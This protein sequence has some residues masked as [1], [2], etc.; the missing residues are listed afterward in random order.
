V[1]SENNLLN[2]DF[3]IYIK[4]ITLNHPG[5]LPLPKQTERQKYSYFNKEIIEMCHPP[6]GYAHLSAPVDNRLEQLLAQSVTQSTTEFC[7]RVS[8]SEESHSKYEPFSQKIYDEIKNKVDGHVR[9][10]FTIRGTGVGGGLSQIVRSINAALFWDVSCLKEEFFFPIAHDV[11]VHQEIIHKNTPSPVWSHSLVKLCRRETINDALW[12]SLEPVVA[13]TKREEPQTAEK[14]NIIRSYEEFAFVDP[15]GRGDYCEFGMFSSAAKAALQARLQAIKNAGIS[16]SVYRDALLRREEQQY[17]LQEAKKMVSG[18][19]FSAF[20]MESYL[21]AELFDGLHRD[22]KGSVSDN[23]F[24]YVVCDA[25]LTLI[26]TFV[27]E[28]V[29]RK[30]YK[31]LSELHER[32]SAS[33]NNW[34][35]WCQS[36]MDESTDGIPNKSSADSFS[37]VL[38]VRYELC[39]AEYFYI[40]DCAE[41]YKANKAEYFIGTEAFADLTAAVKLAWKALDR[42]EQLLMVRLAK[43][44]V[45]NEISQ[46]TFHPYYHLLSRIYLLRAKMMIVHPLSAGLFMGVDFR[47]PTDHPFKAAR[48]TKPGCIHGGRLFLLERARLYAACDGD[49]D[50]YMTATAYQCWSVLLASLEQGEA[51]EINQQGNPIRILIEDCLPWARKLRDHALLQY[52]ETGRRCYHEI[53]ELSGLSDAFADNLFAIDKRRFGSY[54]IDPIPSIRETIGER[55]PGHRL[56]PPSEKTGGKTSSRKEDE[57]L[58]LDMRMLSLRKGWVDSSNPQNMQTIYL[59]GPKS[60]YLFFIR[61]LYHLFSNEQKEFSSGTQEQPLTTLAAWDQKL[62]DCYQLFNYAWATADDGCTI[63]QTGSE[64]KQWKI[65][66]YSSKRMSP[67][68]DKHAASVWDLYPFRVTEIDDLGKIFAV[69]CASLRLYTSTSSDDTAAREREIAWLLERLHREHDIENNPDCAEALKGQKRY[70]GHLY[71]RLLNCQAE[72]QKTIRG[73][74]ADVKRMKKEKRRL[75]EVIFSWRAS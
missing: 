69:V 36:Y 42:A 5:P 9:V 68:Q 46:A 54:N 4:K 18:Y 63:E 61:G 60:A 14:T 64:R 38:L 70:N 19:P 50:L 28:G 53:K 10:H 67:I 30:A 51:V 57:V 44:H 45:I 74:K 73:A 37:G 55:E 49:N 75:L 35:A 41:E 21:Q 1:V 43:Y 31:Y 27:A 66:R 40:L 12:Q 6:D 7:I 26:E 32:L 8:E 58:F 13:D 2:K 56:L 20:A 3:P 59:F 22:E 48:R 65:K 11:V 23:S 29:Y 39:M 62:K 52:E 17:I 24:S 71:Q 25:Y 15:E 34:I 33:S 72:I 16:A 47:L